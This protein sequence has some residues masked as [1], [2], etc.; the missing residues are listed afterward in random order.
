M[1]NLASS[2]RGGQLPG[3]V[4][5]LIRVGPRGRD[6]PGVEN[7]APAGA[8]IRPGKV[9]HFTFLI[10]SH[11]ITIMIMTSMELNPQALTLDKNPTRLEPTNCGCRVAGNPDPSSC[12]CLGTVAVQRLAV[13]SQARNSHVRFKAFSPKI[14]SRLKYGHAWQGHQ[15]DR[16]P[17]DGSSALPPA[18]PSGRHRM[19]HR[20]GEGSECK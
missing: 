11:N 20:A 6:W 1:E 8:A 16:H 19:P 18:P 4:S 17:R 9:P 5:R 13:V 7:L 15:H 10:H 3:R 12:I 14:K 2:G